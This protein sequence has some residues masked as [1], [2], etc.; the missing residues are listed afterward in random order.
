M[1]EAVRLIGLTKRYGNLV[2]LDKVCLSVD[3]GELFGL[4]GPDGSG[5]STI[6]Q[7]LSTLLAP[8]EGN[9]TVMGLD[10]VRDSERL[11]KV[12]GYMP[13]RFSLYQDLTVRENLKFF[14]SLFGVSIK[15]NYEL[16]API[17]S[18]LERFPNRRA[19]DLSGGMKQKLALSCAL[20]HSPEIL[21][22]DEPTTGV[23]AVS[24][25]E[26]WDILSS[27]RE[28]GITIL[29]STSYMDEATRCGRIA[30]MAN[31]H[32]LAVDT[33]ARLVARLGE[34]LYNAV[35]SDMF[36]LLTQLREMSDVVDCYTF[37]AT[38]HVVGGAGFSSDRAMAELSQSGLSDVKIYPATGDIEDLFIKF[39][40]DENG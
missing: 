31:G 2:A 16:I 8:D 20:I 26:F 21:L 3:R 28:R 34:N 14:A 15:E 30:M 7:I 10:T 6:Y 17:F 11:R 32:I 13:E 39:A 4:I 19:G 25:N 23:D 35:S 9:A 22:L 18:Q 38:L 27:L 29:V 40:R 37:G 36:G 33:P 24:R 12:I 5:K 1:N